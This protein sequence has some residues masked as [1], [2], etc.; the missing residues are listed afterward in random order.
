MHKFLSTVLIMVCAANLSLAGTSHK[1]SSPDARISVE[2][3]VEKD[4]ECHILIDGK[5]FF[6]SSAD[7][8]TEE[9]EK[10]FRIRRIT[11]SSHNGTL[12]PVVWQKSAEIADRYNE[13]S[14]SFRDGRQ[15][16]C[17]VYDNG[18]AYRWIVERR[19]AFRIADEKAALILSPDTIIWYPNETSFYSA[20]EQRFTKTTLEELGEGKLC[21]LPTLF[22][23]DEYKLLVTESDLLDY[24]GMWM[25]TDKTAGSLSATFPR[26]PKLK[27]K[28]GDRDEFV[29]EREEY[30]AAYDAG[31]TEFPWRIFAIAKDDRELL[32][33]TL[34]YQL[35]R[36]AEGDFSWVRP[37]KV[38]WDWWNDLNIVNVDFKAGLNTE[39]YKYYIDF[40]AACGIDYV[41]FDEGW[42]LQDDILNVNPDMDVEYLIEY[43]AGKGVDVILW[44]TWLRLD[45]HLDEAIELFDS[46][47]VRGIKVD[48]MARDDQ[49]MVRFY[50]RVARKA[51]EHKMLVDFHGGYKP[52]GLQRTFP[53]VITFEGVYGAEQ[54]KVDQSKRIGPEH[55][56]LLPFTRMVAGPMDYTP[57]S[58]N[59]RHKNDWYP[60]YTAPMGMGTRCHN[61]AMYV[62]FESPL[63]MLCDSPSNYLKEKECLGLIASIPTV[64]RQSIPLEAK[65][66]E[67]VVMARESADGTWYVAAMT[68]SS[69]R[70]FTVNLDFLPE[71]KYMVE[72]WQDGINAGKNA[73]DYRVGIFE[74]EN[75]E[76]LRLSLCGEGGY[77]AKIKKL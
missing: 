67:Y 10:D 35:A 59:N 4:V 39:T 12:Y 31:K 50:T 22:S 8:Q 48:F 42:S 62:I 14:F 56:L 64:W 21:S 76:K 18:F 44:C 49:D 20:N 6:S 43:A 47:G 72:A 54:S 61:M 77:I 2:I 73:N 74:M 15:L 53:N 63:Q 37:G 33:N 69:G 17:R 29:R 23:K 27:E 45:E 66:G 25:V 46:W 13:V 55:N 11:R 68:D 52:A 32:S 5:T 41:L 9:S 70:E 71:G 51:A 58:V 7:I 16:Q 40:A 57:G 65:V 19:E 75:T 30:I 34:P 36:E 38:Q 26:Y 3:N 1:I 24:A 28:S 60:S